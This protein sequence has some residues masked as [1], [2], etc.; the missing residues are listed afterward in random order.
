M[1]NNEAIKKPE[2]TLSDVIAGLIFLSFS[3]VGWILL[4]LDEKRSSISIM[5]GDPGPFLF[6]KLFLSVVLLGG[7]VLLLK[8]LSRMGGDPFMKG[9]Y[10]HMSPF[11]FLI[12]LAI[13]TSLL[14]V[15]GSF[16]AMLIFSMLWMFL[17]G[18][19]SSD[20]KR[21]ALIFSSIASFPLTAL[22]YFAFTMLLAVPLP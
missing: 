15:L 10:Q 3:A 16:F 18:I 4:R 19:K 9:L 2:N 20:S 14:E 7:V 22:V 8:G 11:F 1:L 13:L 5:M 17:I 6:P 12:S 21:G